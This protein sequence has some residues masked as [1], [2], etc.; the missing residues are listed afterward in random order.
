[1]KRQLKDAYRVL[2]WLVAAAIIA[3]TSYRAGVISEN[4]ACREQGTE[5]ND[6]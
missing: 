4:V 2:A 1:M 3:V 6:R 5:R